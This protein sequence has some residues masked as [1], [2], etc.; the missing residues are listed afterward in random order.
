MYFRG[1]REEPL[2]G[3]ADDKQ[4]E[5]QQPAAVDEGGNVSRAWPG[6]AGGAR[7]QADGQQRHGHPGGVQEIVAAFGQHRERVRRYA[8]DHQ[9]GD[10]ADVEHEDHY[11]AL[12]AGHLRHFL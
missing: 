5:G 3:R 10:K 11:Q 7:G 2:G 4:F 8:D 1:A 12:P 9:G 6:P